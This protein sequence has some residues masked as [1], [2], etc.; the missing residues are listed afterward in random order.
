MS[1]VR[2]TVAICLAEILVMSSYASFP[3]LT[4]FFFDAWGLSGADAGWINGAFFFG[5]MLVGPLSTSLTD[6]VDAR[7]IYLAGCCF[8]T[9]GAYGFAFHATDFWSSLPWRFI[10]GAGLGCSYMPGLKLLTDRL[11]SGDQSRSIAFYTACFS[12]GSAISFLVVGQMNLWVDWKTALVSVIAG[13][14]LA[15]TIILFGT[16]SKIPAT[17]RPWSQIVNYAPVVK[18]R[19]TMGYILGYVC[20]TWELVAMR[21]FLLAFL[22]YAHTLTDAPR[23]MDVS[24]I[25]AAVV[26]LGL[27]ASVLGNELSLKVGRQRSITTIMIVCLA[28]SFTIGFTA[29][30]P[31]GVVVVMAAIYGIL[32]TADSS[33]LTA[34][35]IGSA[36]IDLKGGT[37][38]VHSFLGFA[39]GM[40]GPVV[41]GIVLDQAGGPMMTMGWGLMFVSMGAITILGPFALRMTRS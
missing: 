34:G 22:A 38:A 15:A 1:A 12:A 36:P 7:N 2:L 9:I 17:R 6:R 28:F 19:F 40:L 41:A 3:A 18:N 25:T 20:H 35:A 8:A 24:A 39:G 29:G 10:T 32:I 27:P 33:S 26:F 30:F 31:F 21:S 13:P 23:W 37:L 5:F 14:P 4:P 16:T 11:P